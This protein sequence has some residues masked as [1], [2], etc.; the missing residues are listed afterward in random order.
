[1]VCSS[2]FTFLHG[3]L[4]SAW[5][6]VASENLSLILNDQ[7]QFYSKPLTNHCLICIEE[8]EL[9]SQECRKSSLW[10]SWHSVWQQES[11]SS[12]Y[13]L[14]LH[15]GYTL[16]SGFSQVVPK[17]LLLFQLIDILVNEGLLRKLSLVQT[18]SQ[19]PPLNL[20]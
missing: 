20:L 16:S 6:F 9:V 12:C 3:R 1:M 11:A 7:G 13:S 15:P 2:F 19:R 18:N 17:C 5:G 10:G 14:D 8:I 4:E